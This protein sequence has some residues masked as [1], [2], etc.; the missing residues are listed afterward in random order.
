[1]NVYMRYP[2]DSLR[3]TKSGTRVKMPGIESFYTEI[4]AMVLY[5]YEKKFNSYH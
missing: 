2:Y 5:N 1:M 3:V 4:N